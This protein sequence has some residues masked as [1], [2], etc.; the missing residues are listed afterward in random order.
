MDYFLGDTE[1]NQRSLN[2]GLLIGPGLWSLFGWS[3]RLLLL[4]IP[5]PEALLPLSLG[6]LL[7]GPAASKINSYL[8]ALS[9][10]YCNGMNKMGTEYH[11]FLLNTFIRRII[12]TSYSR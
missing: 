1:K 2:H 6:M 11:Y 8:L 3:H 4:G 7:G 5:S 12:K 9:S 10:L